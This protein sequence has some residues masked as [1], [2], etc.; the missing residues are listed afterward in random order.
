MANRLVVE[1]SIQHCSS[2]ASK[3][4]DGESCSANATQLEVITRCHVDRRD[5]DAWRA[6]ERRREGDSF[7]ACASSAADVTLLLCSALQA[8]RYAEAL[9]DRIL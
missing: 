8:D 5:R 4:L 7:A 6:V 1:I 3:K 9:N 2:I